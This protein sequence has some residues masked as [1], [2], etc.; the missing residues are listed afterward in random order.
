MVAGEL[1]LAV[2]DTGIG[3][4][5]GDISVALEP[6]RQ[7]DGSLARRYEGTGLGLPL[8]RT[9]AELHGGR[10]E[11]ASAKGHGTTVTVRIPA[12]AAVRSGAA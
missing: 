12:V 5:T 4:D 9:F 10:L 8:A 7:V 11:I 1:V 2:A 6:F 3:M